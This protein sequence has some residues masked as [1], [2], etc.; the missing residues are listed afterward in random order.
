MSDTLFN[1]TTDLPLSERLR[2]QT[3]DNILGQA[4]ILGDNSLLRNMITEDNLSSF[5]LWGPPGTGK[6]SI[7][8]VIA[9]RTKNIWKSFSA[10][11]SGIKEVKEI[12]EEASTNRQLSGRKTVLFVDEIHRFNKAQQDAFL[13][14]VE[15]GSIIL[16]GATTENPSFSVI[17]PSPT[18]YGKTPAPR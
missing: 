9:H 13:P 2:P 11:I 14:Y 5:I 18:R 17:S 15:N 8:N 4:D 1:D 10:V 12:M 6:T 7:A 16:I 3:L